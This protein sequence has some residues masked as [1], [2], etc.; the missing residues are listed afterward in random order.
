MSILKSTKSGKAAIPITKAYLEEQGF[1]ETVGHSYHKMAHE[2][3]RNH[4]IAKRYLRIV[5]QDQF[6]LELGTGDKYDGMKFTIP[7]VSL[8]DY[9]DVMN[10]WNAKTDKQ[11]RKFRNVLLKKNTYVENKSERLF[12]SP[13]DAEEFEANRKKVKH[14]P[15]SWKSFV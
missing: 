6:E 2:A 13:E 15:N 7:I 4:L 1:F 11:K 12:S 3:E 10:F 8:Q 14:S 5:G 9:E